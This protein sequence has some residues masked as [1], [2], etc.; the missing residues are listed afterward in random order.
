ME[1]NEAVV[2]NN[3]APVDLM[4]RVDNAL[5]KRYNL[6]KL[7]ELK[8]VGGAIESLDPRHKNDIQGN[9]LHGW[10]KGLT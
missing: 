7:K 10:N 1:R 3:V 6:C 5:I 2:L 4:V 9:K 8:G